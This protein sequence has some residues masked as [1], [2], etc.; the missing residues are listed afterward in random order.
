MPSGG[1]DRGNI[2]PLDVFRRQGVAIAVYGTPLVDLRADRLEVTQAIQDLRGSVRLVAGKRTFVRFHA[3]ASDGEHPTYALLRAERTISVGGAQIPIVLHLAPLNGTIAVKASPDRTKVDDAFLFE[4]PGFYTEGTVKLTG[5]LNPETDSRRRDPGESTYENNE[6]TAT[7]R[8]ERVPALNLVLYAMVYS[9]GTGEEETFHC[10]GGWE[11]FQLVDWMHRAYPVSTINVI[12]RAAYWGEGRLGC[13]SVNGYLAGKRLL[14]M[15][16][17]LFGA[18]TVPGDAHYYGMVSDTGGFMRGC[19]AGIPSYIA[20]GP[21]GSNTWGWDDDGSY[22]DWYG[23]HE[24][25]HTYGRYHAMYCGATG[26]VGYPHPNGQISTAI[27]GD[28][29]FYGFDVG[30]RQ[31]Y[32]P[33][34]WKDLMTYC[35]YLWVSDFTYHGLLDYFQGGGAGAEQHAEGEALAVVGSMDL[36]GTNLELRPTKYFPRAPIPLIRQGT[37][38]IVLFD[39]QGKTLARYPFEP[40]MLAYGPPLDPANPGPEGLLV[41][42]VVPW[43]AGTARV[44]IVGPKGLLALVRAGGRA[45]EV[46]LIEPNGGQILDGDPIVVRW[47]AYD[48]QQYMQM[49]LLF[50]LQGIDW[51]AVA[52]DLEETAVALDASNVRGGSRA[53]FRVVASDGLH[54]TSD[55]SDAPNVVPNRLPDVRIIEPAGDLVVAYGQTVAFE[56]AAYDIDDG[57]LD[58]DALVWTSSLAGEL[59]RGARIAVADLAPGAHEIS[60]RAAD[61]MGGT[62]AATVR[63]RVV[64]DVWQIP[65]QL[66][67][68]AV[69]PAELEFYPLKGQTTA[70]LRIENQIRSRSISWS[71]APKDG[72][73]SVAPASGSTPGRAIVSV[74]A[75]GFAPGVHRSSIRISSPTGGEAVVVV[76]VYAFPRLVLLGSFV[77]GDANDDGKVDISD[78]IFTLGCLFQ[79]TRC[80]ECPDAADIQDDGALDISD[81]IALLNYLFL[82]GPRPS[83][84]FP[85]CGL[86]PT[87]DALGPCSCAHCR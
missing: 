28:A 53:L 48:P 61:S 18:G 3:S 32:V 45:P 64:L 52:V 41:D 70:L 56:G 66:D 16:E 2:P 12:Y 34:T 77:R 20:S 81:P 55:E 9:T 10:P 25:A 19:A 76:T 37:H 59:G 54:A 73:V 29:A 51:E 72:W 44:E 17:R 31:V 49:A 85:D 5:I 38:E 13:R 69:A 63:V 60:L 40:K 43:V 39:A 62:S 42:E 65:L 7:A 26:G 23:A 71:A 75:S 84:P 57:T 6:V 33:Q 30:T 15:I 68:L 47:S 86:D 21:T 35:D 8:F 36:D 27:T 83:A 74:P 80:P 11:M 22:G 58:G 24:L 46:R 50:Q 78:A 87:L 67:A 14:D 1:P 4:L 82:E 79:G